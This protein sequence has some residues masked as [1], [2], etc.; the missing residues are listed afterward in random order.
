MGVDKSQPKHQPATPPLREVEWQIPTSGVGAHI[1]CGDS[2][3][4]QPASLSSVVV[5]PPPAVD[6]QAMEAM[7]RR[8]PPLWLA[9]GGGQRRSL[10]AGGAEESIPRARGVSLT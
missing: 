4:A 6:S 8:S 3:S 1:P 7:A 5:L 9:I 10:V 2:L